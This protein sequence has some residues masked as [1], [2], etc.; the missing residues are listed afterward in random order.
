MCYFECIS[1]NFCNFFHSFSLFIIPS[2]YTG[3]IIY[4]RRLTASANKN[5]L[6][7]S[8]NFTKV[9]LF[10][11][12]Q[13]VPHQQLIKLTQQQLP[14]Y[15]KLTTTTGL[16]IRVQMCCKSVELHNKFLNYKILPKCFSTG[17]IFLKHISIYTIICGNNFSFNRSSSELFICHNFRSLRFTPRVHTHT[18]YTIF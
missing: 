17:Y 5:M 11:E 8:W 15:H 6:S 3:I 7:N 4:K 2:I 9:C 12:N 14:S 16:Y 13:N 1:F 10:C 18:H